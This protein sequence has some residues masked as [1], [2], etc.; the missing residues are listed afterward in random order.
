[1]K[2]YDSFAVAWLHRDLIQVVCLL[3]LHDP[4]GQFRDFCIVKLLLQEI[5]RDRDRTVPRC[6]HQQDV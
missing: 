6:H 4:A 1:M 2:E 5:D 3:E